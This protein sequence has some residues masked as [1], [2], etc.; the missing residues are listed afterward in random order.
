MFLYNIFLKFPGKRYVSVLAPGMIA[1]LQDNKETL[2]KTAL[3]ALNA[4]F[5][6]C[7]GLVPFLEGEF[8][9]E[10]FSKATNPNIKSELCGWLAQVLPKC[11]KG[12]L[13]PELKAII[14]SIYIFI[15][16]RSPEVR[17][18]SQELL[19][20]LM[21]H[22]GPNDMLRVMQ[23]CKPA[24]IA[25]IQPLLEKVREQVAEKMKAEQPKTVA[26]PAQAPPASDKKIPPS[27]SKP[28]LYDPNTDPEDEAPPEKK[29]P[30]KKDSKDAKKNK[31]NEKKA[32]PVSQT[33]VTKK[34]KPGEE[35]DLSPIMQVS[36]KN[37]RVDEEKALKTLK[38]NF[39]V[40]RKEF[41]EQ[42]RTQMENANFNRSLLTQMFHDDFQKH[43]IALNSLTKAIEDLSEATLSNLD[44]ILRWLTLRFF[45]TNPTVILKA[46][47]YM[48]ALFNM[49]ASRGYHLIEFE[50]AAFIPYFIGKVS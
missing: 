12:K 45:E 44:L 43:I 1:A 19:M 21:E 5:D 7:G 25:V 14:P 3:S 20:P 30:P 29:E 36:N 18:K 31:E 27:K 37:K 47:E 17:T 34:P 33:N 49:L 8:L 24:S 11:K 35:E 40:P 15:E 6:N 9:M 41:I 39:D 28:S 46:I 22:V 4:W 13:P 10:Q 2:R 50:A 32:G 42:L 48:K 23:K 26:K 38:W 16:D